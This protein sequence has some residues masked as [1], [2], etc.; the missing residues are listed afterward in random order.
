MP[1]VSGACARACSD[2]AGQN[3]VVSSVPWQL[4][5]ADPAQAIAE[6]EPAAPAVPH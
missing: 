4:Q 5:A 6:E 1:T 3:V 2:M